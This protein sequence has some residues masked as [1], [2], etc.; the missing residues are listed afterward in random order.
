MKE[1]V[2][3]LEAMWPMRHFLVTCGRYRDK[4]NIIT[5]SFCMPV[6]KAPPLI[7]FAMGEEAYSNRLLEDNA[8]FV[9]NV[10]AYSQKSRIYYCG[11]H[12]GRDVDKFR[13]TGLTARAGRKVKAPVIRECIAHMECRVVKKLKTGDKNLIVGEVI[14]SYAD[15]QLLSGME[16]EDFA[17]GSFPGQIYSRRFR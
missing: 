9:I 4:S 16:I 13:E 1:P 15:K 5:V 10:P 8:E 12:S 11:F 2:E 14:E 3:Y 6:S 7:A 17:H